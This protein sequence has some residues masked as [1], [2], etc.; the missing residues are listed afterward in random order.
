M[1]GAGTLW[2]AAIL[3]HALATA[4]AFRHLPGER[5]MMLASLPVRALAPGRWAAIN[6]TY[7]GLISG[8]AISIALA[9]ALFLIGATSQPLIPL[10]ITVIG[11]LAVTL[12]ASRLLNL[13]VEGHR[14][15]F[16]IGGAAFVGI[17]A[18]PWMAWLA[19]RVTGFSA[20]AAWPAAA[21]MLGALAPAYAIGEGIGRLACLSFGCCYGK[22]LA[23][24]PA[25]LQR[26][27]ARWT[28]VF[29]GPL[30]KAATESNLEGVPLLPV[31][32]L[33]V[34]LSS[35]AGWLGI[36][37]FWQGHPVAAY[38][39]AMVIT[40]GWRF[41]SEFL[42]ADY[43][44]GNR[45]SAYQW[46]ALVAAV[47]VIAIALFWPAITPTEPAVRSGAQTLTHPLSL[48]LI[49]ITGCTLWLRMGISTVTQAEIT[50]SQTPPR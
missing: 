42:R 32:Q 36:T 16:T 24:S 25:W 48:A 49:I 45:I 9:L 33:T 8:L 10:L 30:K 35:A 6:L 43:R 2:I 37:L 15:G 12:P 46:M 14:Q 22:P 31:Q 11:M 27:F 47:Y 26:L 39:V 40:Q 21:W 41:A 23:T 38:T 3:L 34:L 1:N 44:G 50:F 18:V 19:H 17:L 7:Y 29:R 20:E 5:W 28:V 4:W 13:L